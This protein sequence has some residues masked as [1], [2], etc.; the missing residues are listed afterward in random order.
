MRSAGG[1]IVQQPQTTTPLVRGTDNRPQKRARVHWHEA[2][3]HFPISLFGTALLFQVLHL[4]MFAKAFELS[5]TVCVLAGAASA[6]GPVGLT[7]ALR[8]SRRAY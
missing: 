8:A 3:T 2:L 6:R 4:F 1:M 7:D 5:T